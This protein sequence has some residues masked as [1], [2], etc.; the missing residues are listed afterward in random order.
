[1]KKINV[2]CLLGLF[3]LLLACG[4]SQ[5]QQPDATVARYYCQPCDR[6]CDLKAYDAQ[7]SCPYCRMELVS[8]TEE[9]HAEVVARQSEHALRVLVY[10]Q[11]GVEILDFAGP[12]EVFTYA[13]FD[14]HTVTTDGKSIISQ[15]VVE[16]VPEYSIAD[17]P[18]ADI[19]CFF[20]GNGIGASQNEAVIKW[21]QQQ[22]READ[23]V[24]SVCTGAFFLGE[25]GLLDGITATTFHDAIE[26]L[27]SR[28]PNS[29]VLS[30]ARWVDNGK[31]ITTA[32]ISA[33]IDGAL[34]LVSKISGPDAATRT[35]YYMEYDKWEP[36]QGI[37]TEA[38]A[39]EVEA[40]AL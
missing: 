21:L 14:V 16:V 28:Y 26:E 39:T 10:L 23:Y 5:E 40:S 19:I 17:A 9:A 11:Q 6:A 33:G 7:G 32:G 12:V 25:A 1:M 20:G 4:E 29:T 36:G 18:Q 37:V 2:S 38:S 35:A 31:V 3:M 8:M 15:G 22:E 34:H 27:R 24:F 30:D 13:G